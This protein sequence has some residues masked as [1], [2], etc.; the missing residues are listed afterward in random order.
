MGGSLALPPAKPGDVLCVH[1]PD[2]G[3]WQ[4]KA[5]VRDAVGRYY[6]RVSRKRDGKEQQTTIDPTG[7]EILRPDRD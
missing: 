3:V 2:I 6:Y 5:V 4:V 7:V 1:V